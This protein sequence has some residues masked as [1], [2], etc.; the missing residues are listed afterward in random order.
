MDEGL[1]QWRYG[2]RNAVGGWFFGAQDHALDQERIGTGAV[3]AAM[4]INIK[5]D[6]EIENRSANDHR[7]DFDRRSQVGR[8]R[9]S[10]RRRRKQ[11]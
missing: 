9:S 11:R 8:R 4:E 6:N 1:F 10:D 5:L 2:W 3:G 7:K